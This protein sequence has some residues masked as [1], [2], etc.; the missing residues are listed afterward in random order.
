MA[1]RVVVGRR[2]FN[3][4]LNLDILPIRVM[5]GR[6]RVGGAVLWAED[7]P[8]VGPIARIESVGLWPE[9]HR[10]GIGTRIYELAAQ[11]ACAKFKAPLGSSGYRTKMSEGFWRKQL[12]KGR[13]SRKVVRT[14]TKKR[15]V[16]YL[17]SCPA[18]VS[19][20]GVK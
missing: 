19:L 12:A 6:K 4:E 9:Y 8:D 11:T 2:K 20:K 16:V 13:A 5:D 17:L 14:E 10:Q 3:P 15:Q 7:V 18:P 1:I